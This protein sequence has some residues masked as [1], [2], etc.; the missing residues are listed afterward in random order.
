M[1]NYLAVFLGGGFGSISRLFLSAYVGKNMNTLFPM[2]TLIVNL[3]GSFLI[4]FLFEIFEHTAFPQTSRNLLSIGFLGGFTTFSAYS[5]ENSNLLRG[6][7][8][9]MLA[10]NLF[11]HSV[12]GLFSV[13]LGIIAGQFLIKLFVK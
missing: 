12:F 5:L 7:E 13:F 1:M 9:N 11:S 6:G 4:G 2:G 8:Y 3:L 10:I